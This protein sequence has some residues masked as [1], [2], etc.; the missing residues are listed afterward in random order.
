MPPDAFGSPDDEEEGVWPQNEE[1]L[2]VYLSVDT[3]QRWITAGDGAVFLGLDYAGA[4]AGIRA[5]GL[6]LTPALWADV[7][8][9]EAAAVAELN[10]KTR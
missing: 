1:A 4:R 10:R 2:R 8:V 6:K 9:I 3:Q 5:A 7:Q